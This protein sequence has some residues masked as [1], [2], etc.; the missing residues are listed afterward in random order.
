MVAP[1][2]PVPL[3][4]NI[5]LEPSEK[6]IRIPLSSDIK[7]ELL[8]NRKK[9]HQSV[10]LIHFDQQGQCMKTEIVYDP[11][12]V[13]IV[14]GLFVVTMSRSLSIIFPARL[15]RREEIA[16]VLFVMFKQNIFRT[17]TWSDCIH[18]SYNRKPGYEMRACIK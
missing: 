15:L 7:G 4:R 13:P 1:C 18:M 9:S 3:S 10:S 8:Q 14:E 11:C 12:L 5:S 6:M 2:E 16:S 17:Y